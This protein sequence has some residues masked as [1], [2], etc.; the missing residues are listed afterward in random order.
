MS[1]PVG[2]WQ[3]VCTSIVANPTVMSCTNFVY[4]N[5]IIEIMSTNI[6]TSVLW[7]KNLFLILENISLL[8]ENKS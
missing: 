1:C 3:N 5:L 6:R 4:S 7:L 8:S 2:K